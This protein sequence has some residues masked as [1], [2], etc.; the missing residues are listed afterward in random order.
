MAYLPKTGLKRNL[1]EVF[2]RYEHMLGVRKDAFLDL[3]AIAANSGYSNRR[4]AEILAERIDDLG[5]LTRH[6][7][8]FLKDLVGTYYSHIRQ[9]VSP[10]NGGIH[11]KHNIR[12]AVDVGRTL[13]GLKHGLDDLGYQRASRSWEEPAREPARHVPAPQRPVGYLRRGAVAAVCVLAA[14]CLTCD[15]ETTEARNAAKAQPLT[16]QVQPADR[17]RQYTQTLE[18]T[19]AKLE[20]EHEALLGR[21][22]EAGRP[23]HE[24][25]AEAERQFQARLAAAGRPDDEVR[26]E[27][28]AKMVLRSEFD[29]A[30]SQ[31]NQAQEQFKQAEQ[32]HESLAERLGTLQTEHAAL[33]ASNEQS[34]AEAQRLAAKLDRYR[35]AEQREEQARQEQERKSE[36]LFAIGSFVKLPHF[37]WQ[38]FSLDTPHART[39]VNYFQQN[40]FAIADA[41]NELTELAHLAERHYPARNVPDDAFETMSRRALE[42]YYDTVVSQRSGAPIREQWVDQGMRFAKSLPDQAS[43]DRLANLS[44]RHIQQGR[45]VSFVDTSGN[46][47]VI[48]GDAR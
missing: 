17:L 41:E 29:E 48:Q 2:G 5:T 32:T 39:E 7:N 44:A 43:L 10:R 11:R 33:A 35:D 30:I 45:T 16:E 3:T 25:W 6:E 4:R 9:T 15:N 31:R 21:L 13:L 27:L 12:S 19:T 42:H 37:P 26:E 23:D 1:H 46:T 20:D 34:T 14:T 40:G 8:A 18:E 28:A 36:L 24:V 38:T 47:L 22:D